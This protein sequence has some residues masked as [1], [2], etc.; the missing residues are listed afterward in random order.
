MTNKLKNRLERSDPCIGVSKSVVDLNQDSKLSLTRKEMKV[1]VKIKEKLDKTNKEARKA[2]EAGIKEVVK[3]KRVRSAKPQN[4]NMASKL[5]RR[6][7]R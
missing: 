5:Y 6:S 1:I 3:I 4:K 7:I 2:L